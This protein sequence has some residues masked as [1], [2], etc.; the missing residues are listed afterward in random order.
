M[1]KETLTIIYGV[2]KFHKYLVGQK[3]IIFTDNKP[4]MHL[5]KNYGT[6]SAHVIRWVLQFSGYKY[7]VHY[8]PG[9]E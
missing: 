2:T 9:T 6:A 8:R 7:S 3:F 5:L 4:L 1:I